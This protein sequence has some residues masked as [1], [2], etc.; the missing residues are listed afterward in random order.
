M[1]NT[2]VI[3]TLI[4]AAALFFVGSAAFF[5]V[6][7]TEQVLVRR[8]G[9]PKRVI[10]EPGLNFKLPLVDTATYF[11]KRLLSFDGDAQEIP[12]VDQKQLIV[13]A[14]ARYRIVDTL[15]FFQSVGTVAGMEARLPNVINSSLR[16]VLGDVPL[17]RV[18]TE[19]RLALMR[20]STEIAS[21]NAT[22]FGIEIVDVRLKR[23]DLPEENS[24]AVFR[25]MQTQR[26]QEARKFRAEGDKDSRT[27][28]ADADKQQRVILAEAR[29]TAEI[30]RG[31]GDAEAQAI[32]NQAYTRDED[33][34][35]FWR[36]MQA[37]ERGLG[38]ESTTYVGPPT[39]DFFRFFSNQAGQ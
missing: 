6:T 3:V 36:S 26:E 32:Y 29:K 30:M 2:G 23:V 12:T 13:D 18:L 17:S 25:R 24:Q 27:I 16:Q 4:V 14:F 7:E 10:T 39:G 38:S 28:R 37:M 9:E 35:D 20:K 34:F 21:L 8:F 22:E 33:F 1:R 15:K 19:E 31:E 5:T 11:E